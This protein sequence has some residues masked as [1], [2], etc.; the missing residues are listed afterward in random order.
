MKLLFVID[1]LSTGGAQRQMV[2]L[3]VGLKQRGHEVNVFCYAPGRM[4]AEPLDHH[5]I[6]LFDHPKRSRYS[7]DVIYVLRQLLRTQHYDLT[8]SY[9]PTPNFY[10]IL[11]HVGLDGS[12]KLVVSERSNDYPGAVSL[13]Q[14]LIRQMY[15]FVNAVVVNSNAQRDNLSV[16]YPY[17]R[18]RIRVI[19]NG[20]DLGIFRPQD[21]PTLDHST[22]LVISSVR[23]MKN[24]ITLVAALDVLRKR[25]ALVPI[26][27]WVGERVGKDQPG[28]YYNIVSDEIISR[29]LQDQWRW[30]GQ[31]SDVPDLLNSHVALIHPSYGEGL[32]NAVCEALACGRPV[33]ASRVYDNP[34]LVQEGGSGFLFE[35]NDAEGLALA[36]K[37]LLG[38]SAEQ[39]Q[40]MGAAG[41]RYAEE[42]LSL[43]RMVDQYEALFYHLTSAGKK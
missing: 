43:N 6:K 30:L 15:R 42:N 35:W 28:S 7:L 3:A 1:N 32:P 22:L 38:M 17:L 21:A 12:T 19:Y 37:R 40:A 10:A 25:F 5:G 31:R 20:V 4:L 11:S 29:G 18:E 8:L 36:I 24:A 23:Q 33:I 39:R 26:V 2:N 14:R 13:Q 9:L 34:L 16:Q 27:G 41:R